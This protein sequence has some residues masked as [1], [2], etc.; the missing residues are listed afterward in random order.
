MRVTLPPLTQEPLVC[1]DCAPDAHYPLRILQAHWQNT[2]CL[3][4]VQGLPEGT[5]LIYDEMNKACRQ[6]AAI[7]EKAI[8]VMRQAIAAGEIAPDPQQEDE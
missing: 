7:L 2:Q 5:T 4:E 8:A 1:V 6:R 3:F